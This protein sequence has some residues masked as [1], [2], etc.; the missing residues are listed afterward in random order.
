M[1][2][3][4][5]NPAA[6]A[7]PPAPPAPPPAGGALT[8]AVL[9]MER[10][11]AAAGWDQPARLYALVETADLLRREP[12]LAAALR[13]SDGAAGTGG[14]SGPEDVAGATGAGDA[15]DEVVGLDALTPVE[16]EELPEYAALED[17][18]AGIAWPTEVLGAALVVERLM[19]PPGAERDMPA[20]DD[21]ALA[22]LAAHPQRQEVRLAAG[23]LRDGSRACALRLRTHDA[24][25]AVLT[26]ADLV[27]GLTEALAGT[28]AD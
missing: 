13:A 18:L 12:A 19:L 28:L 11:V 21:A 23:V 1:P 9:E 20:G 4:P 5:D 25:D 7:P 2:E 14:A 15:A 24:D 22:W 26:G 16:Q 27:P 8:R 3:S 10:H 17:L 6:A